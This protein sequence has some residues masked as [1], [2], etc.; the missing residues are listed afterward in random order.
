MRY[1]LPTLLTPSAWANIRQTAEF[2]GESFA[3]FAGDASEQL[4]RLPAGCV[5][6]CLTSPPYW[7]ARN[8]DHPL[9]LGLEREIQ[10]YMGAAL[11]VRDAKR[12]IRRH[13]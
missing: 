3:L 9:Q 11:P 12:R 13:G 7:A 4:K 5:N 10:D 8:Y 6:T 2:S 1:F